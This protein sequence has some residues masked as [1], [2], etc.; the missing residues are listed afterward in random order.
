MSDQR[1]EPAE[2]EPLL[3]PLRRY[4]TRLARKVEA[5]NSDMAEAGRAPLI[6]RHAEA[7]LAYLGKVPKRAE[8]VRL[9]DPADPAL[10]LEIDLDPRFTPQVNAAR[11]FKRAAKAE[12]GRGHI[13]EQLS[14]TR[15]DVQDLT[16]VLERAEASDEPDETLRADLDRWLGRLPWGLRPRGGVV[17]AAAAPRTAVARSQAVPP[18]PSARLAPRR[19]Q[20]SEGWAVLVGRSNEGN[21]YVT[22]VLARPEDYWFHVHGAAGSHVVLRRGKGK[23]EPSKRTLEEVASWTAWFS[24]A[25]TAGKVPVIVT[26]KKYVR[27]PRKAPPGA[28]LCTNEKT[29]IV[30]PKEPPKPPAAEPE[31][32]EKAG[33]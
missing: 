3:K 18:A 19:L 6:R 29:L 17:R 2:L 27:R 33:G 11:L 13:A 32:G 1:S 9:P 20:S 12:R 25:R 21:D 22:H 14:R 16:W 5:L 4:L 7:L 8:H 30:R 23:N 26:R 10:T 15:Q 28:A 24:Q 31:N